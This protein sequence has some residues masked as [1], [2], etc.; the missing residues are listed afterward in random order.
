MNQKLLFYGGYPQ[1]TPLG[2]GLTI[3]F[4]MIKY[5]RDDELCKKVEVYIFKNTTVISK[6]LFHG[7]GYPPLYPLRG[8]AI[9]RFLHD[10]IQYK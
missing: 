1:F 9:T 2:G 4:Y 3:T 5:N 7:G 10:K 8:M 6:P